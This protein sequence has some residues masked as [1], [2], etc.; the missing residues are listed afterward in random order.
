MN[1]KITA[2]AFTILAIFFFWLGPDLKQRYWP[3][4]KPLPTQPWLDPSL[5]PTSPSPAPKQA[6]KPAPEVREVPPPTIPTPEP[7]TGYWVHTGQ[8]EEN[9]ELNTYQGVGPSPWL[10][11]QNLKSTYRINRPVIMELK[12]AYGKV[13]S[14]LDDSKNNIQYLEIR[15][16]VFS[17]KPWPPSEYIRI[18]D[19]AH[20]VRFLSLDDEE[21]DVTVGL[22]GP[23]Q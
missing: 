17:E 18:G 21:I 23:S 15:P 12:D 6:E 5:V 9:F 8:N 10:K 3:D 13:T 19:K 11:L 22:K 7:S 16:G 2:T 20:W 1:F 4:E 14:F